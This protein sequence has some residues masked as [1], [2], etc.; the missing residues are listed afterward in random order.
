MPHNF[1]ISPQISSKLCVYADYAV[2]F[3]TL[4]RKAMLLW[5]QTS[6]HLWQRDFDCINLT[7]K[8]QC[9][10]CSDAQRNW[11]NLVGVL[12]ELK[13]ALWTSCTVQFPTFAPVPKAWMQATYS[14]STMSGTGWKFESQKVKNHTQNSSGRNFYCFLTENWILTSGCS[15]KNPTHL[16]QN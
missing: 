9:W 5:K 16:M 13:T 6:H 12:K 1:C 11:E 7:V 10:S 15:L 4:L 3:Y 14:R 2:G 8:F